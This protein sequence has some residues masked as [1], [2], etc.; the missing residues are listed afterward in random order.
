[1]EA[2]RFRSSTGG[3]SRARV[4]GGEKRGGKHCGKDGNQRRKNGG[5]CRCW[6]RVAGMCEL[7]DDVEEQSLLLDVVGQFRGLLYR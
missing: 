7:S 2:T 4:G 6:G 5:N 1:M 3:R